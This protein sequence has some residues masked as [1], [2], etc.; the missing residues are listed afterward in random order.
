[1]TPTA[2]RAQVIPARSGCRAECHC[3]P[4]SSASSVTISGTPG[5]VTE[6]FIPSIY[7]DIVPFQ[8]NL[9]WKK[10]FHFGQPNSRLVGAYI[11]ECQR[12]NRNLPYGPFVKHGLDVAGQGTH[13]ASGCKT[14]VSNL[15]SSKSSPRGPSQAHGLAAHAVWSFRKAN[16]DRPSPDTDAAKY[17]SRHRCSYPLSG[18]CQVLPATAGAIFSKYFK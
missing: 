11:T 6:T 14:R 3:D 4:R 9:V 8:V 17:G 5:P 18:E 15:S 12:V 16:Q 1:M 10:L 13:T 2:T 7:S